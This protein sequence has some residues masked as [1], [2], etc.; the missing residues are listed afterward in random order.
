MDS[1]ISDGSAQL[2]QEDGVEVTYVEDEIRESYIDYAMSVIVG[3]AL[4][5]VRDG[6]K[7][8]Q[9]RILYAMHD[10]G[11]THNSAHKKSA[12]IVGEVLGKYHPHGDSAVYNT[13]VRMAQDFSLR[14]PLVDPQGNFGSIDGDNPA[15]MR[16]TE[17]KLD[18][19][20]KE[21]LRN[22]DENTVDFRPNFD[23][24]LEEP[25]VFPGLLPNLLLNGASGIAVG[26]AT[27]IP[28]HQLGEVVD[29]IVHQIKNPDC[30]ID[31]LMNY[32]KGPDFP[33]G[34]LICSEKGIEEMYKTGRG[35][36][37]VRGV[38]RHVESE[39]Q[40]TD[41]LI[42]DEIPYRVGK[43]D[44]IEKVADKVNDGVIEGIRDIRDESDRDG[45][46][47]VI[48]LSSGAS[49]Q[50]VE[51]Q[52]YKHTRLENTFGA[53]MLALVDNEPQVLTLKELIHYYIEHQID[54]IRRRTEYRLKKAR[55][56]AHLLD[57]YRIAL[58][59]IDEV[60][61]II[62][63][64][65]NPSTAQ[66]TLIDEYEVSDRQ[67]EAIL[68]MQLQKLTSMEVEKIETEYKELIED[69]EYYETIL[70][71]DQKVREILIDEL[72]DLKDEFNDDRRTGFS[73]RPLDISKEDL[74]KD[75][76]TIL[77]L[78]EE[79]YI[80]RSE[81]SHFRLQHRGG[82]G[83]Y[84]ADPKEGDS[85]QGV[86]SAYTHD[87]IL[88]FTNNGLCYWLKVYDVPEG[89]RRTQGIPII[90]L[91]DI[92]SDEEVRA[93]IPVRELNDGYL[94]MATESGLVKK[95]DMEAFSRPRSGGII[96]IHL[97]DD[98]EL[99]S[100]CRTDGNQ[101]IVL[102]SANG[103]AIRFDETDVRPTGRDTQG[104]NGIS[105]EGDDRVVALNPVHEDEALLTVTEN[106]F[107]KRTIFNEYRTQ[108]RGG[109]GLIDIKTT[110]R[111]GSVVSGLT[112]G[113]EDE[114]IIISDR[115]ILLRIPSDEI[116]Q[117]GRNTHGVKVMDV[118]N[119]QHVTDIA[120][121]VAAVGE[122][123]ESN[124]ET[125]SEEEEVDQ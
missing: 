61:Q 16:Y 70:E 110:D 26:M 10:L 86:F 85:I 27:N 75:E 80:K 39:G 49:P 115:G 100:V 51:N 64:S 114:V 56:R 91:I 84:G 20:S 21:I 31:E 19:I 97:R 18:K 23:D 60:V 32:I 65:E 5:D 8:V 14:Y 102:Q 45:M 109:K 33:T 62:K 123:S 11:L 40:S 4:P 36:I 34:G 67:A 68:R 118:M 29:A 63:E 77:T 83:I 69:I 22:I 73:D 66:D 1:D 90:N 17:A 81:P 74:I 6:M 43:A 78:S 44:L 125:K 55:D 42:I 82:R 101:D 53:I 117:I 103:M 93:V 87:Y 79:G 106:G 30:S 28:P 111:N 120:M 89:G 37:I 98:D 57:G 50:I 122:V 116:S 76:P 47:I 72:T 38:V 113:D 107:G 7:P 99:I 59:N 35:R 9:R 25:T 105:L 88:V 95:T 54:V 121:S 104:V 58:A 71:S 108:T 15:A 3:R 94:V 119:Q 96:G 112:V 92:D 2:P 13:L 124:E 24:S 46:R 48:E 12:R 52:L 41:R